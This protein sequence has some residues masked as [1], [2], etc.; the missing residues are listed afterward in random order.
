MLPSYSPVSISRFNFFTLVSA[1]SKSEAVLSIDG[2][3]PIL[4]KADTFFPMSTCVPISRYIILFCLY[5]QITFIY[6]NNF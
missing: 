5:I 2:M 6:S 3:R 1:L 4:S